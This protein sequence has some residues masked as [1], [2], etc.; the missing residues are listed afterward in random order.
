MTSN[1]DL[2]M[3]AGELKLRR[4]ELEL[5]PKLCEGDNTSVIKGMIV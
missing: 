5:K 4:A 2:T 3:P 1:L